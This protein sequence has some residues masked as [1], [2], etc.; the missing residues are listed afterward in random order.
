MSKEQETRKS[1]VFKTTSFLGSLVLITTAGL[2]GCTDRESKRVSYPTIVTPTSIP[3]LNPMSSS[4]TPLEIFN[5]GEWEELKNNLQ[6][7]IKQFSGTAAISIT[8]L[9]SQESI[10]INGDLQFYPASAI[11][12]LVLASV[13]KDVQVGLYALD[14]N[15]DFLIRQ[16]MEESDNSATDELIVKTG[17]EKLHNFVS[18]LGM[19]D[20]GFYNGFSDGSDDYPYLGYGENYSTTNDLNLFWIKLYQGEILS[21]EFTELALS[22]AQLPTVK[23]IYFEDEAKVFHKPGWLDNILVDAGLVVT[24]KGV[25]AVSFMAQSDEAEDIYMYDTD[26][27]E[28]GDKLTHLVWDFFQKAQ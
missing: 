18:Q 28:L 15:I 24:E 25:Y 13:L 3:E 7:E 21:Q 20:S 26:R 6:K 5:T 22:Y 8:D 14:T 4:S 19:Q 2:S 9:N 10:S 1:R 17:L 12:S 27:Y 16:M 11:K 23:I